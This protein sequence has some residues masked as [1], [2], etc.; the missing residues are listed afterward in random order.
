M[1]TLLEEIRKIC[2][3]AQG[4]WAD[5]P[6]ENSPL[7]VHNYKKILEIIDKNSKNK[8]IKEKKVVEYRDLSVNIESYVVVYNERIVEFPRRQIQLLHFFLTNPNKV[9]S[10]DQ[11]LLKVWTEDNSKLLDRTVDVHISHMKKKVPILRDSIICFRGV[12]YKF[13]YK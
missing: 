9:Y 11:L 12:G 5:F 4:S 8:P 10:R 3:M 7:Q 1:E 13:I 2:V 6:K